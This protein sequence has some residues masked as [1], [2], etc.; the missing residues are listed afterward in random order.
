V[1]EFQ[2]LGPAPF[3]G[4]VLADLGASVARIERLPGGVRA[5]PVATDLLGRGKQS[6]AVD[7]KRPEG[8]AVALDLIRGAD[9]VVEGFRPGTMERLGLGPEVCLA[10]NPRLVFGRMTGWG[11]DG[12]LASRAG[13][14]INYIGLT[15]ALD[16]IGR[17]GQSPTVPLSL[18]G[19]FGGGG[20]L[21]ALGICAALIERSRSGT[22]QVVD[23]AITDGAAL[24]MT[25]VHLLRGRGLWND[26]RGTNLFDSGAPFY[27][28][29]ETAD[30]RYVSV[31][32][33]EP[34]FYEQFLARLGPL[35]SGLPAQYER[36]Q[37]PAAKEQMAGIIRRRTQAEWCEIFAGADA[38]VTPVLSAAE[39]P[40]HPHHAARESYVT[41]GGIVQPAPAP[42]FQR[43][44]CPVPDPPPAPGAD[45]DA[46][47]AQI[48]RAGA[49]V[50]RLRD[51]GVVG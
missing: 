34:Q 7:L 35:A 25:L 22:G 44:R 9:V 40:S 36:S 29:Y 18:V 31:G 4:M 33:I 26:E 17:R 28:V 3:C 16:A 39:A 48:G 46:L 20:L 27:D 47:L 30:G 23:A 51:M 10:E 13:H 37:W 8:R 41:V 1:V 5:D 49:N 6:I 2:G 43:S 11:Q 38:C 12:P 45:T 21:L 14:D 19:D 42:R 15:G 24:L 32:A 50:R